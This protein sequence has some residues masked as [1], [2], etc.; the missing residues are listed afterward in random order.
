MVDPGKD[1]ED[2]FMNPGPKT[3]ALCR[4]DADLSVH[5]VIEEDVVCPNG[6][7]WTADNKTMYW[8]DSKF[9][10]FKYEYDNA[11]AAMTNRQ[12]F[13]QSSMSPL[14][15][16]D[17]HVIDE[18]D[19]LWVALYGAGKVVRVNPQGEIVEEILLQDAPKVTCPC[20]VGTELWITSISHGPGEG[21][22]GGKL[23]K[24][25]VGVNGKKKH[26]F[27]MPK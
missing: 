15:V 9:G 17:G 13:L 16:P 27:K 19:H 7:T 10:I 4:L 14:A 11:T 3:N 12:L 2:G 22:N 26:L 18:H 25:D 5:R 24:V 23:F 1:S 6:V 8:T 20:F 21:K